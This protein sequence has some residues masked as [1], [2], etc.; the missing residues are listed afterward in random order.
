MGSSQTKHIKKF[1]E[2]S[3]LP[4]PKK[5]RI[6]GTDRPDTTP[7]EEAQKQRIER[8]S[9]EMEDFRQKIYEGLSNATSKENDKTND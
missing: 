2:V 6:V 9:P 1:A 5:P 3:K 4:Q 8:Y 7:R